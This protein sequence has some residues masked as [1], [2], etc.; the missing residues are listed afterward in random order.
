MGRKG[1]CDKQ[2]VNRGAWSSE[3]D[4][5][6]MNY[7]RLHGEGKWRELSKRAGIYH[8]C[9]IIIIWLFKGTEIIS[10]ATCC[11]FVG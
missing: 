9:I 4:Q 11:V 8:I 3:E 6:L 1:S 5:I 2:E 7:V 10:L